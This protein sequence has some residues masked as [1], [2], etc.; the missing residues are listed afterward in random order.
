MICYRIPTFFWCSLLGC[1]SP[2]TEHTSMATLGP[3]M[4]YQLGSLPLKSKLLTERI[5]TLTLR[6]R[7]PWHR[8]KQKHKHAWLQQRYD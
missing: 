3:K 8:Q 7:A 1:S 6:P 4:L 2:F 5:E